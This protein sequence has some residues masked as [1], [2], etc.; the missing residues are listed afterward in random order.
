MPA[1]DPAQR[2]RLAM[3]KQI[4]EKSFRAVTWHNPQT[5]GA[6]KVDVALT[7]NAGGRYTLRVNVPSDFPNSCPELL[8]VSS[9]KPIRERDG[10]PLPEVSGQYHTLGK[11]DGYYQLC[12]FISNNW[13]SKNTLY[14]VFLKGRLWLEAFEYHLQTGLSPLFGYSTVVHSSLSQYSKVYGRGSGCNVTGRK[15]ENQISIT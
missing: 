13:D 1:W 12:H 11:R 10:N 4:L 7:T 9:S 6:T 15:P 14:L 3:E 5:K 8:L 2:H